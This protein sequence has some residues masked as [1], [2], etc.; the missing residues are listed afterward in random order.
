MQLQKKQPQHSR[1]SWSNLLAPPHHGPTQTLDLSF[2]HYTLLLAVCF[3]MAEEIV[4][5]LVDNK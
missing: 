1:H 5:R 4:T 3:I 2:E